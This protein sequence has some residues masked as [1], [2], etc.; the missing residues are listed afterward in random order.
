M[1]NK[2]KSW[3]LL[4]VFC[5]SLVPF[6]VGQAEGPVAALG[7]G[8][9]RTVETVVLAARSIGLLFAGIDLSKAVAGP[10]RITYLVGEVAQQGFQTGLGQGLVSFFNFLSLISVMLFFMN[11]LPIPVLDGGQ[12]LLSAFEGVTRRPLR[13][14]FVYR[15]QMI[16]TAIIFA[17]I[18][19]AFLS[20]ILF[21]AR[22]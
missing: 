20:D 16:G 17:I 22:Q 8:I 12:I 18:G 1:K 15:Y 10:V 4:L 11:M 21:L 14:R 5:F 19:F 9:G 3:T 2:I 7:R 13:P 6:G